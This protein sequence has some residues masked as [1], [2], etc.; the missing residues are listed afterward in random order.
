MASNN[1]FYRM[2]KYNFKNM[3]MMIKKYLKNLEKRIEKRPFQTFLLGLFVLL[4]LIIGGN[5][6]RQP[7]KEQETVKAVKEVEVYSIG[8][9]PKIKALAQVEKSGVIQITAPSN[10]IVNRINVKEGTKVSKGTLLVSLASNYAG[11][12]APGIGR[13]IAEKQNQIAEST[14]T[15]QTDLISQ[16]RE[17]ANQNFTNFEKMR[18]ITKASIDDTKNSINLNSG[19]ISSL[20]TNIQN[21]SADP[22]GNAVLILSSQQMLSQFTSANNQLNAALR[23]SEYQ[24]DAN[25]SPSKLSEEQKNV[26][27]KQLDVQEKT[28]NLNREMSALQLKLARVNEAMMFPV[29]PFNGIVEQVLVRKG[30]QVNPGTPLVVLSST[31]NQTLKVVAYIPKKFA[32]NVSKLEYTVFM[33]DGQKVMAKPSYISSEAVN[34]NMYG[35]VYILAKDNYIDA[36]DKEYVESEIPIGY[37]DSTASAIYVPLDDIYQTQEEAYVYKVDPESVARSVKIKLGEVFGSFVRVDEGLTS[38]DK[39]ISNRNIVDGDHVVIN[40]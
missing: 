17:L 22:I 21:L 14:Y 8:E 36:T 23:N 2:N 16:Q 37:P 3:I 32:E 12:S 9:A 28:L 38:G 6:F 19:I 20:N 25:N 24:T 27:L 13:E 40:K 30:Q 33:I 7:K 15:D 35:V 10:S 26:A 5:K 39:I 18:D 31:G 4:L 34:G 1:R 29:A 11:G